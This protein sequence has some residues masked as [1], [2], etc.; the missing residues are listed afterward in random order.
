M[1]NYKK[2]IQGL[3]IKVLK[4]IGAIWVKQV[5]KEIEIRDIFQMRKS[6]QLQDIQTLGVNKK[7]GLV[8]Y[9]KILVKS[10]NYQN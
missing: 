3:Q 6:H 10:K 2:A 1:I 8:H 7:I 9:I 5:Q 4:L